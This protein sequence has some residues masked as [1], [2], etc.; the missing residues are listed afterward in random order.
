MTAGIQSESRLGPSH[1]PHLGALYR[2]HRPFAPTHTT[3]AATP[4]D[5]RGNSH[6]LG[7]ANKRPAL[8]HLP[9]RARRRLRGDE[10]GGLAAPARLRHRHRRPATGAATRPAPVVRVLPGHLR[11]GVAG[12]AH[13][14]AHRHRCRRER[15][16]GASL[17]GFAWGGM[18]AAFGAALI[19]ALY[20]RGFNFWGALSSMVAGT[21]VAGDAGGGL[22]PRCPTGNSHESDR[23]PS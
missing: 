6:D 20:W 19:L 23:T 14:A 7:V 13:A 4:P 5:A 3:P 17:V 9:P 21:L 2:I 1:L 16:G 10:H 15:D 22:M 11:S 12:P 8:D 18:G